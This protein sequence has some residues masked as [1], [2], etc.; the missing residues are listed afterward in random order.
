MVA[1][2]TDEAKLCTQAELEEY[3]QASVDLL[4]AV[5]TFRERLEKLP[6]GPRVEAL[7]LLCR[8]FHFEFDLANA[9]ILRKLQLEI[10]MT[11]LFGEV[12]ESTMPEHWSSGMHFTVTEVKLWGVKCEAPSTEHP[13]AVIPM[14]LGWQ[15]FRRVS[16]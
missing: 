14:R 1:T 9:A 11:G 2:V 5:V 7:E 6:T 15:E 4:R 13:G 12:V 3:A 10:T 8:T 16:G